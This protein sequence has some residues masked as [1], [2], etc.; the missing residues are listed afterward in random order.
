MKKVL[1]DPDV[2]FIGT[3]L[4]ISFSIG[5]LVFYIGNPINSVN[6]SCSPKFHYNQY[7]TVKNGFYKGFSGYVDNY[8]CVKVDDNVKVGYSI[9]GKYFYEEDLGE[10]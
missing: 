3:L 6:L 9:K 1:I 8:Q 5:I 2:I 4:I 7:L 10:Q